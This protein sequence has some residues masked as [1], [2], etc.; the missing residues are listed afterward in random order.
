[1][2]YLAALFFLFSFLFVS[3]CDDQNTNT[4]PDVVTGYWLSEY[5][6]T[7][8]HIKLNFLMTEKDGI[9]SKAGTC[10]MEYYDIY[11][12]LR[13]FQLT[14]KGTNNAGEIELNFMEYQEMSY[15]GTLSDDGE[16][17]KGRLTIKGLDELYGIFDREID[18]DLYR[19]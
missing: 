14:I 12:P 4:D 11:N 6:S 10:Y 15:T 16:I 5:N 3:S 17:I 2:K 18:I 7:E 19:Q 1:M 8:L 13:N 9:I